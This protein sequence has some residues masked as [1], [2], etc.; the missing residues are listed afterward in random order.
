MSIYYIMLIMVNDHNDILS[1]YHIWLIYY[2]GLYMMIIYHNMIYMAM[3]YGGFLSRGG[4]PS[5]HPFIDVVF[6]G[7]NHPAMGVPPFM[8]TPI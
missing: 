2:N 6:Y 4:S 5:H 1:G 8:E 7:I 3:I